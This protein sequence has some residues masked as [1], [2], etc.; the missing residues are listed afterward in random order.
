MNEKEYKYFI[1]AL[2]RFNEKYDEE[3]KMIKSPFS[4][5]GYHTTLKGGFVH[6]T[7]EAFTYVVGLLD[8]N[9]E[10]YRL[11]AIEILEKVIALQDTN[12]ENK[13]YGI[14]SWFYEE[15]LEKMAPPDW[16]WADFCGKELLQVIIDHSHRLPEDL[17]N[18]V[19]TSIMHACKSIIRRNM[20]PHY[21]NIAIM[22]TYV[23][24]VAG[25]LLGDAE[26]L[27][28]AKQRLERVH[29]YNMYHGS[30]SEYNSP[31]YT[32]LALEDIS[33]MLNHVKDEKCI[34]MIKDLNEIGWR[35]VAEHF[36]APT[37][38][39]SG[40]HSRCY[41]TLQGN[42]LMSKLQLALDNKAKFVNDDELE[43]QL[44]TYRIKLKCP[45]KYI[46]YF[47][48]LTDDRILKETYVKGSEDRRAEMSYTY[49]N[50]EYSIGSFYKSDFWNQK[51]SVVAYFGD[52]EAPVYMYLRC[53]HDYYDYSSGA[54]HT[55][56]NKGK[57]L[58]IINFATNGGD[59]HCNL[60]MVK[61]ATI[62]AEDIR[63]RVELGGAIKAL[64]VPKYWSSTNTVQCLSEAIT[65]NV[66]VPYCSFGDNEIK[67]EIIQ[68]E[69]NV[70]IDIVLYSG[71]NKDI[72]F[73]ELEEAVCCIAIELA[74]KEEEECINIKDIVL[75]KKEE[76][77][78]ATWTT[79]SETLNIEAST[80]AATFAQL[81]DNSC[82]TVNERNY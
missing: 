52:Y 68:R 5:P 45:E 29:Q 34:S 21:T 16:N 7:R 61:N 36:H 77:L 41:T 11:R 35:C 49:L 27:S 22:G 62:K 19:K 74:S 10:E 25:E 63:I 56:Q 78:K 67:Y 82:G 26:I 9:I 3:V 42:T 12:P 6:S 40:P 33:R 58:S 47:S 55:V 32:I 18:K 46:S 13:T 8:S 70:F 60:D 14:W 38:Q 54:I 24:L 71:E 2:E 31:S 23:T 69:D 43:V 4:S 48:A 72:C 15:P 81:Y 80:K 28:Y 37:R 65:L 57:I 51:R 73:T 59:T 64:T 20:G 17:V 76:I 39:W 66:S 75:E 30:F 53:L 1:K 50:R 79:N 44:E